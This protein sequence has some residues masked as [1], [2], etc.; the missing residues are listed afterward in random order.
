[1]LSPGRWDSCC[2]PAPSQGLGIRDT[3]V[4]NSSDT[5]VVA[6]T[7]ASCIPSQVVCLVSIQCNIVPLWQLLKCFKEFLTVS[8]GLDFFTI[9]QRNGMLL[10]QPIESVRL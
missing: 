8:L 2:W 10:S 9:K 5:A 4:L 1:M 7:V 3:G 6:T